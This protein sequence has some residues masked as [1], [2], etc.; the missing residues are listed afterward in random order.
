MDAGEKF[1]GSQFFENA[2]IF[3]IEVEDVPVD[4][5]IFIDRSPR[6]HAPFQRSYKVRT[7]GLN[8][9]SSLNHVLYITVKAVNDTAG[10][11]GL[12]PTVL[13]F[14]TNVRIAD[15]F[16]PS[17][18]LANRVAAFSKTMA[19]VCRIEAKGQILNAL[20]TYYGPEVTDIMQHSLE[21][22][23]RIWRKDYK[24]TE[25]YRLIPHINDK[26]TCIVDINGKATTFPVKVVKQYYRDDHRVIPTDDKET[27]GGQPKTAVTMILKK[28]KPPRRKTGRPKGSEKIYP[29]VLPTTDAPS[30][31]TP[32]T[33]FMTGNE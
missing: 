31:S 19:Q 12:V 29:I 30:R 9:S 16:L 26:T 14:E 5:K 28:L 2:E 32:V 1:V 20:A 18:S 25:P 33:T 6:Y 8:Y 4:I 10:F 15:T 21:D 13:V 23:A 24:W 3:A 22:V 11:D 27:V 17:S 7:A